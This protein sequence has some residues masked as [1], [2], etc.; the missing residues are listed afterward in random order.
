MDAPSIIKSKAAAPTR[1]TIYISTV[2]S[3]LSESNVKTQDSF[4]NQRTTGKLLTRE[5][6]SKLHNT[7]QHCLIYQMFKLI[8]FYYLNTILLKIFRLKKLNRRLFMR[9][10]EKE[11][12]LDDGSKSICPSDL[13]EWAV[14]IPF[15]TMWSYALKANAIICEEGSYS[16]V[17]IDI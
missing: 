14:R 8:F 11:A 6:W 9:T 7:I 2:M 3:M 12:I 1:P 15:S 16:E 4:M 13:G 17:W 5:N 10:Y